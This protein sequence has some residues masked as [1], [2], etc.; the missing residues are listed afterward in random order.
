M[1]LGSRCDWQST[2]VAVARAVVH[3]VAYLIVYVE[4]SLW[5]DVCKRLKSSSFFVQYIKKRYVLLNQ[6][7][8]FSYMQGAMVWGQPKRKEGSGCSN[9][10][11]VSIC[12]GGWG[13]MLKWA[14]S[15]V[16]KEIFSFRAVGCFW[17]TDN[18]QACNEGDIFVIQ[19]LYPRLDFISEPLKL[20]TYNGFVQLI[21]I[22]IILALTSCQTSKWDSKL[23]PEE[24][25]TTVNLRLRDRHLRGRWIVLTKN[26]GSSFKRKIEIFALFCKQSKDRNCISIAEAFG[27]SK[28]CP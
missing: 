13:S 12:V 5:G 26:T 23:S 17:P 16:W 3:F 27:S 21:R 18:C 1:S 20:K 25:T 28:L 22:M 10:S 4:T 2:Q 11:P 19:P 8:C 7:S 14:Y 6:F 24:E 15:H 9:V